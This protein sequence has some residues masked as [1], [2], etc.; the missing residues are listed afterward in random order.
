M[1]RFKLREQIAEKAFRENRR[2]TVTEV[3]QETGIAR[4]VVS[5]LINQRGYNTQTANLDRLCAYFKCELAQLVE[6]VPDA[7]LRRTGKK[8]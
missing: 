4:G 1:I 8:R 3:A 2:I 5:A 6:Y 7:E